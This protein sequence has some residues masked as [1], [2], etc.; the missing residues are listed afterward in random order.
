MSKEKQIHYSKKVK[1]NKGNWDRAARFDFDDG[2]LG[3]N[4]FDSGELHVESRILLTPEQVGALLKF[5]K[6]HKAHSNKTCL[7]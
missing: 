3:I 6:S 2:Y 1:G 4:S 5:Y 7:T